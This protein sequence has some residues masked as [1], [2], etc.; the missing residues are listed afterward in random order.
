MDCLAVSV[1]E[2]LLFLL[3]ALWD[4]SEEVVFW[5]ALLSSTNPVKGLL[6][7]LDFAAMAKF[8]SLT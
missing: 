3:E 5:L 6:P 7:L 2:K 1:M 8:W 4:G